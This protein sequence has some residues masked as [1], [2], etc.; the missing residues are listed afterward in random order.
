MMM[1]MM[2][3]CSSEASEGEGASK[4]APA[5]VFAFIREDLMH[6]MFASEVE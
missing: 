3:I 1:M 6:V 5:R 4:W 2:M